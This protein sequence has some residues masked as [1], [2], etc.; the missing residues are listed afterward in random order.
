[1]KRL[2]GFDV[3]FSLDSFYYDKYPHFPFM[4]VRFFLTLVI[5]LTEFSNL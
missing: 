5:D 4:D 1:M 2:V 3:G